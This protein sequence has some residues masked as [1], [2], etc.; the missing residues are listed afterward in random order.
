MSTPVSSS[1]KKKKK[2]LL[3]HGSRQTGQLLL[4]RMAKLRRKLQSL[5]VSTNGSFTAT[6]V[7]IEWITIDAPFPHPDDPELRQWWHRQGDDYVGLEESIALVQNTWQAHA[8][9]VC[10]LW[11]FSQGA[12]LAHLLAIYHTFHNCLP[13]LSFVAMVS[14]YEAPLPNELLQLCPEAATMASAVM[15]NA[16]TTDP[17]ACISI[18]S[19][20][21]WGETDRIIHPSQSNAVLPYYHHPHVYIHTGGHHVPMRAADVETYVTFVQSSIQAS[22]RAT[23]SHGHATNAN[24]RLSETD[25]TLTRTTTPALDAIPNDDNRQQQQDEVEAMMAIFPDQFT[26]VS[27]PPDN[28][29]SYVFPIVYRIRIEPEGQSTNDSSSWPP[30]SIALQFTYPRTYPSEEGPILQLIHENNVLQWSTAHAQACRDCIQ[31]AALKEQGMPCALS[32]V[33]AAREYFETPFSSDTVESIS[34]GLENDGLVGAGSESSSDLPPT[35]KSGL[36]AGSISSERKQMCIAEG[37]QVV[38]QYYYPT[39]GPSASST[40]N[41]PTPMSG[42]G[43]LWSYTIGLI[44]KPSAGKSTFFNVATAFARQRQDATSI[45]GGA[46]MAAHPFTTIDP[47]VGYCLVPAPDGSCPEEEQYTGE[48]VE[49]SWGCSHG[50]DHQGRRLLPVFLKDVAGL[51]PG[52]YQG[53]GKGNQFLN[54]L[55]DADVLIHVMDASGS[56]DTE[57]NAIATDNEQHSAAHTLHPLYDLGWIHNELIEWVYN[58]LLCKWDIIKRKGR[59]KLQDMFSGYG[60]NRHM[61]Q[62][63]LDAVEKY[64]NDQLSRKRA[65]ESLLDWDEGDVYRLVSAFLGARFPMALALNKNDLPMSASYVSDIVAAL[66]RHGAYVGVSMSARKEV[67]YMKHILEKC[68]RATPSSSSSNSHDIMLEGNTFHVWQ[69]LQ[70]A[71]SLREPV[72]VFPVAEFNQ[73]TPLL[74]MNKNAIYD[75]SLPSKGMVACLQSTKGSIPSCWDVKTS[76]YVASGKRNGTALRDA[77][78]MKPGSTVEDVFFALKRHGA[79]SGEFIRAEAAPGIGVLPKPVSK[80]QVLNK[81]HRI[82]K[83]MTN[84]QTTG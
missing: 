9:E 38:E 64:M 1:S 33:Y 55:C 47:N 7:D 58:N 23:V 59:S 81:S 42:K 18:P 6:T 13:G 37:L 69:C 29:E 28:E 20:H 8:D 76:T 49:K 5:H 60:Q 77:L 4:G 3:L 17:P 46:A 63:V 65:L 41:N 61:T 71:M 27:S 57:G 44:G 30:L 40:N 74:G 36:V 19:L 32:C 2:I 25:S 68:Y 78:Q 70:K 50:R 84:K 54:D 26:W 79:L 16:S 15:S 45:L 21:V 35:N 67:L 39:N 51:V 73:Y 80:L 66:P 12:R 11:G 14:G 43:G 82:L 31:Q 75:P 22:E 48:A 10:G 62:F 24:L 56:L 34:T 52:A 72:V 83:I 53:R